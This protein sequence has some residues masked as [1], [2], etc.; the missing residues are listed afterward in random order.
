[1]CQKMM[2]KMKERKH[3]WHHGGGNKE[4]EGQSPAPESKA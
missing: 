3:G 2:E 1:M 4:E